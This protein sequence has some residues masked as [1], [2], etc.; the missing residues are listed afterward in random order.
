MTPAITLKGVL[1]MTGAVFSLFIIL[2]VLSVLNP[3][4]EGAVEKVAEST[5]P[6]GFAKTAVQIADSIP[7]PQGI[8]EQ[9][10]GDLFYKLLTEDT[11][12]LFW[13]ALI[14]AL[15]LILTGVSIK[16]VK[17]YREGLI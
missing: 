17:S 2:A 10:S 6:T 9:E 7:D 3:I 4:K 15:I 8:A 11:L 5:D 14:V 13:L 16:K 12:S 1:K